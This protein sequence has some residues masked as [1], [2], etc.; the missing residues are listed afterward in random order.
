MTLNDQLFQVDSPIALNQGQTNSFA[1]D[2]E[3]DASVIDRSKIRN[4]AVG[5]A[6]IGTA[7]IGS[8]N[9]ATAVIG[10]AHIHDFNFSQGTGGTLTLGGTSN[11]NGVFSLKNAGGT[12]I[13]S[14]DNTGIVVN[15]GS[16]TIKDSAGTT[17][18]DA[19]GLVSNPNFAN[20]AVGT[21]STQETTSSSYQDVTGLT[22]TF[23][24]TRGANVLF[25]CC[26]SGLN[27]SSPSE[28]LTEAV[29]D[30]DGTDLGAELILAGAPYF[31]G[32]QTIINP[33]SAS[34]FIVQ[35][36][37]AGTHTV[38]AK[39]KAVFGGTARL[40]PY[41]RTLMYLVLGT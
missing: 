19:T 18:M 10:S 31:D 38:K 39:F 7:A 15:Q 11:G 32:L 23:I 27:T 36:V 1:F 2:Y 14:M 3:N 13:I 41:Q 20:G 9:I 4:L 21:N 29:M 25:G 35:N 33:V 16:I 17:I 5:S 37:T 8:A 26:L 30:L 22:K 34:S 40:I 24:L 28:A 6:Q 12:E